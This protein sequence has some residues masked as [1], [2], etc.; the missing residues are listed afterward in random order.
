M[1]LILGLV[2]KKLLLDRLC[3]VFAEKNDTCK[4]FGILEINQTNLAFFL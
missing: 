2:G 3:L 1:E 4:L